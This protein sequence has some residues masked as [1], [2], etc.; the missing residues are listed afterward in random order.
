MSKCVYC[1][2]EIENLH[3]VIA[4]KDKETLS[5]CNDDCSKKTQ[6]FYQFFDHTKNIFILFIIVIVVLLFASSIILSTGKS[7]LGGILMGLDFVLLGLTITIFPFATPQ[8]FSIFG[9]KKTLFIVRIFGIILIALSP[10]LV[11]FLIS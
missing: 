1:H 11:L 7:L 9:I 3:P 2:K 6:S 5:C 8:T 10:L 4:G